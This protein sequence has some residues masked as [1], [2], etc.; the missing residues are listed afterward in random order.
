[1][2]YQGPA[3][4]Y[5]DRCGRSYVSFIR[6]EVVRALVLSTASK[7]SISRYINSSLKKGKHRL[8]LWP[9]Q[10]ADGSADSVTPSKV[11]LQDEMGRLEKVCRYP[12]TLTQLADEIVIK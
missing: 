8:F 5:P 10:E 12:M 7:C 9:E 6:Q 11:E 3:A 2:G 1:M 4:G